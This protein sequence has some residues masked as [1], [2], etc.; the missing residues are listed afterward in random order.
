VFAR[1][2]VEILKG[3]QFKMK[4]HE[5]RILMLKNLTFQMEDIFKPP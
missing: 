4:A 5:D 1:G 3:E 2:G